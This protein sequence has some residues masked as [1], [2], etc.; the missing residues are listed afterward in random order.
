MCPQNIS[1]ISFHFAVLVLGRLRKRRFRHGTTPRLHAHTWSRAVGSGTP[2]PELSRPV[3]EASLMGIC[4][5][6][7]SQD[8]AVTLPVYTIIPYNLEP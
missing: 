4:R 7:D 6:T 3:I 8:G 1:S 5:H 2:T